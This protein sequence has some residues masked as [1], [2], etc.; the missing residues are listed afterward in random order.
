MV[1]KTTLFVAFLSDQ[2]LITAFNQ[3]FIH[4]AAMP[5]LCNQSWERYGWAYY[6]STW[7]FVQDI[8]SSIGQK[9]YFSFPKWTSALLI[10]ILETLKDNISPFC[11]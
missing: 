3:L 7:S 8:L 2:L 4:S 1:H 5:C 10:S 11:Y 9:F 6:S